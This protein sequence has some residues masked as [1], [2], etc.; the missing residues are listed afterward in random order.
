MR[1]LKFAALVSLATSAL[2]TPDQSATEEPCA[3]VGRLLGLEELLDPYVALQCLRSVP[4]DADGDAAQ[5]EGIK[6][7]I[8][9]FQSTLVVYNS[10][11]WHHVCSGN[12]REA[13][14]DAG[15]ATP[16]GDGNVNAADEGAGV[17][18]GSHSWL[19]LPGSRS[20]CWT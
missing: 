19:S 15:Q 16:L 7:V 14:T 18:Q 17:P 5:L 9:N 10:V 1:P 2:A 4:L 6:A 12:I 20:S 13:A 3:Y 11:I 8:A